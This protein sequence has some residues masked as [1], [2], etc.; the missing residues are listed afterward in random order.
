[1]AKVDPQDNAV[2][3][4][5]D[6]PAFIPFAC[7]YNPHTILTKNGE[8]LQTIKITGFTYESVNQEDNTKK[9]VRRALREAVAKSIG[10]SDFALWI[11]TVRRRTDLRAH[12]KYRSGSFE[13]A[14]NHSWDKHH[15]WQHKYVNELYVTIIHEGQ[16]FRL[17]PR[18]LMRSCASS[19]SQAS[20]VR[21]SA[22]R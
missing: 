18:A 3:E 1:M 12:G 19:A 22:G 13:E 2:L 6:V 16:A 15:D 8:L 21:S 5:A 4:E 9:T 7:H 20:P 14:V 17:H 11:H 10:S